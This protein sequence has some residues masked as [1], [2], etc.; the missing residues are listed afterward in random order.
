MLACILILSSCSVF[1]INATSEAKYK[2]I[3]EDNDFSIREYAPLVE[4]QTTINDP[5]YKSAIDKGFKYLFEYISGANIAI[6]GLKI[7]VPRKPEQPSNKIQMTVPVIIKNNTTSW[8]IAFVLP[9]KYSLGNAP[10]PINPQVKLVERPQMKMAVITFNGFLDRNSI[11]ANTEKLRNWIKIHKLQEV[12]EP[13]AAGYNP[14]WT[15]PF[16]RTNEIMIAVK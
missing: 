1:G 13:E 7:P 8:T 2:N 16:L 10:K 3:K 15:I 6:Q 4:A 5:N 9:K 12:G 11:T 14:P